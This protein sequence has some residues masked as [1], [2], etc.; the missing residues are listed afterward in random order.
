MHKDNSNE[1]STSSVPKGME[2]SGIM[3]FNRDGYSVYCR[4]YREYWEWVDKRNNERFENTVSHGK[5]YDAKNMMHVFRLLDMAEEI[6]KQKQVITRRPNREF[7]L[8]IRKGDFMY[9]DLVKQAEEKIE[10][11][12]ELYKKS[13]LPEAPNKD[14]VENLLI[15]MRRE[16]YTKYHL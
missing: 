2:A 13:D 1:V 11:I 12:H 14:Q 8:N 4:E 3:S 16:F 9:E 15:E 5:N 10:K 6:A 7:L